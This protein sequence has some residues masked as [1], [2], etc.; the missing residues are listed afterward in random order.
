MFI[1]CCYAVGLPGR[2][3]KPLPRDRHWPRRQGGKILT[4]LC[5]GLP[6]ASVREHR[7]LRPSWQ[8][9]IGLALLGGALLSH[10]DRARRGEGAGAAHR[11]EE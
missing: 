5:P 1:T 8:P 6:F 3:L 7:L 4:G 10:G 9:G 2:R 11:E